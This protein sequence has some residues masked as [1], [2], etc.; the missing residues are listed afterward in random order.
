MYHVGIRSGLKDATGVASTYNSDYYWYFIAGQAEDGIAPQVTAVSPGEGANNVGINSRVHIRFDESVNPI[1]FLGEDADLPLAQ[2]P[3][4]DARY[5]SL[6]F[7]DLNREVVYV[8][9]EPW[10]VSSDVTVTVATQED[11]AGN[12]VQSSSHTFHTVN[13][14]DTTAPA[15]EEWSTVASAT[16]VPVNAVFKVRLN[17]AVDPITVTAG[18]FYLYDTVTGNMLR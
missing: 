14:P 6:S 1:S 2:T 13:G 3:S 4:P 10:P 11:Y 9:H 16:N 17:E 18:T 15:I 5:Y 12:V 8:P 7:S